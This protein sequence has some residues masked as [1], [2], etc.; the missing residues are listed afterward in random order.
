MATSVASMALVADGRKS[1]TRS[2]ICDRYKNRPAEQHSLNL[3]H[4]VYHH[5][6]ATETTTPQIFGYYD[7]ATWPLKEDYAKYT[8]AIF[9]PWRN[10]LEYNRHSDGTYASTLE[11]FMFN[12]LCPGK[13][14]VQILRARYR[15]EADMSEASSFA[16]N[17]AG[18][19]ASNRSNAFAAS[20]AAAA[21]AARSLDDVQQDALDCMTA[22]FFQQLDY[23]VED[24]YDW[25][26]GYNEDL[27]DALENYKNSFYRDLNQLILDGTVDD[28]Q[29]LFD[30]NKYRPE[31]AHPD[32]QQLIVCQHLLFHYR[33]W[34][35]EVEHQS[36]PEHLHPCENLFVEG[37]AGSGK[38]FVIMT[39]RNITIAAEGH[40]SAEMA[41]AP[42]GCTASLICA[43][44]TCHACNLSKPSCDLC[45]KPHDS[46]A[47]NTCITQ[48]L[49][50]V[51]SKFIFLTNK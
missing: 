23:C 32:E 6:S 25:S 42:T 21:D 24:D 33:K 10:S 37:V 29:V 38:T 5:W 47:T 2:T 26:K 43:K 22:D 17:V 46:T 28:E 16:A 51:L 1:F 19:Q 39:T 7:V 4:F 31:N 41:S 12:E 13:K 44:T 35:W 50:R 15:R 14:R 48:A 11:E 20:A 36:S 30:E 34:Q 3:F 18:S 40:N 9:R 8:L 49:Q 27:Q 45:K